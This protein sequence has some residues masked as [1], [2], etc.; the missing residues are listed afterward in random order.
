MSADLVSALPAPQRLALAYAPARARPATLALLALD[1]RLAGVLRGRREPIA[2]QL[3]LAWWRD[4]LARPQKQW[5]Q[6]EPLIEA[7]RAWRNPACLSTLAEG[8]EALLADDL[9]PSAIAEFVDGRGRA[10]AGLA[11]ELG[12]HRVEDAAEAARVWALADLASNISDGEER[13]LVVEYGRSRPPPPRLSASLRP[14]A[15]LAG[16]GTAALARGGQPLLAGPRSA[17]A[18]LRIGLTGR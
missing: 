12:V 5:P 4:T 9:T 15:V 10:F 2:V 18:A 14:L 3:R 16:L 11:Q 8:W 13:R 1:A 7:L 6:G 17:L